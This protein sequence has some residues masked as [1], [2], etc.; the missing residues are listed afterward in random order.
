[1]ITQSPGLKR[2][3]IKSGRF[4]KKYFQ[5]KKYFL[6]YVRLTFIAIEALI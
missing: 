1:M 5:M 4:G 2:R 6:S 3:N